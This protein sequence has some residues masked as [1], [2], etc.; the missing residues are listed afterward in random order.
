MYLVSNP[1]LARHPQKHAPRV[2]PTTIYR[3]PVQPEYKYSRTFPS[4]MWGISAVF[5]TV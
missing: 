5:S 1:N 3:L 4:T 2:N